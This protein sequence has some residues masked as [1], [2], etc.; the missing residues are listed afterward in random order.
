LLPVSE[1]K[2][3]MHQI[4]LEEHFNISYLLA[5]DKALTEM[6]IPGE[7]EYRIKAKKHLQV[8]RDLWEDVIDMKELVS[9]YTKKK[10]AG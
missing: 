5:R 1:N 9:N 10:E 3:E 6:L 8:T 4:G 2:K 7:K